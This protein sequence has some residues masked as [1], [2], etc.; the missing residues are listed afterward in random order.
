VSDAPPQEPSVDSRD[1]LIRE[2]AAR[3]EA[4]AEQITVLEALVADLR[5]QLEATLRASSRNSSNSSVPPS[6]DDQPGRQP[7]RKQ[8]RAAPRAEKK[9]AV[10]TNADRRRC[11]G[12]QV[13]EE[14][15]RA[16]TLGC[17]HPPDR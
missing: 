6:M 7:P 3:L 1:A 13:T 15:P 17:C 4:Q 12:T 9:T 5:E 11:R 14:Q 10:I 2:Q 8:R 16:T